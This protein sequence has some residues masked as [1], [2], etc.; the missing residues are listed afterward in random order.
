MSQTTGLCEMAVRTSCGHIF[1]SGCIAKWVEENNTCPLCRNVFFPAES[2][3]DRDDVID[4]QIDIME[5]QRNHVQI[6]H[7]PTARSQI[8]NGSLSG[9]TDYLRDIKRQCEIHCDQLRLQPGTAQIALYVFSNLLNPGTHN[10]EF[11]ESGNESDDHV[12]A[13]SLYIASYLTRRPKTTEEIARKMG[14]FRIN[15][16]HD[17][18][19]IYSFF[20][21]N[22]RDE[23]IDAGIRDELETVFNIRTLTWPPED[24]DSAREIDRRR[25]EYRTPT[26]ETS[27]DGR[28]P[29]YRTPARETFSDGRRPEYR[30]PTRETFSQDSRRPEFSDS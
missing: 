11:L 4:D 2:Y 7:L 13:V 5:A 3:F 22:Y 10:A 30:T 26:R 12:I 23:I 6:H 18:H 16:G 21:Y 19:M 8:L 29:E 27:S 28:R 14:I 25:P 1:G 17:L 24:W 15:I 9:I 20:L